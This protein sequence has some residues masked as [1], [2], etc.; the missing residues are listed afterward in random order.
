MVEPEIERIIIRFI[1]LL[2]KEGFQVK[3]AILYGSRARGDSAESADIDLA[4]VI[5]GLRRTDFESKRTIMRLAARID[6]R[7]EPV[8]YSPE[9]FEK[10]NWLPL[11]YS[12]RNTGVEID[13]SK[14]TE[15]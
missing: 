8:A 12:I 13:L 15:R 1:R 7:I 2:L 11:L 10:D 6:E 4:L 5:D 3:R 14:I 9:D